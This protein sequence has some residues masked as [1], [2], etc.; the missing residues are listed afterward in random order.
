L[1]LTTKTIRLF[2][3]LSS[4]GSTRKK[5]PP[6]QNNKSRKKPESTDSDFLPLPLF[7]KDGNVIVSCSTPFLEAIKNDRSYKHR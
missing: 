7:D 3:A 5:N 2:G 6:Y 4:K 1:D